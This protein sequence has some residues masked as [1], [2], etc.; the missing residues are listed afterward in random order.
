[1]DFQ[2]DENWLDGMSAESKAEFLSITRGLKLKIIWLPPKEVLRLFNHMFDGDVPIKDTSIRDYS[3]NNIT[4]ALNKGIKLPPLFHFYVCGGYLDTSNGKTYY[5]KDEGRNRAYVSWMMGVEKVPVLANED[6]EL[7]SQAIKKVIE[8]SG[9]IKRIY[10]PISHPYFRKWETTQICSD[11]LQT[12]IDCV[13]NI[14]GKKVLDIGCF[15]G[16]FSHQLA[17]LGAD[18]VGVDISIGKIDVCNLLSSCYHLPPTNPK[19]HC[20]PYQEY[21]KN[22]DYFDFTLFLSQFHHDIRTDT[23]SAW[24]GL[25]LISQHTDLLF[26]D[27]NEKMIEQTIHNWHPEIMLDYTEFKKVI[28]LKPSDKHERI[29]YA[30]IK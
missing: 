20:M 22:D 17:K 7:W 14:K 13:G 30:L 10:Q 24:N 8:V 23:E 16:Y 9:G 3:V 26:I 11:R 5:T 27:L 18:V 4:D 21:L 2:F 15:F 1:M 12:I 6:F 19:F 25:N 28:P 29:L